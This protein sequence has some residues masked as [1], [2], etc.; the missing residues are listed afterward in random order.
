MNNEK[1]YPFTGETNHRNIPFDGG[2]LTTGEY[3]CGLTIDSKEPTEYY[4]FT[5]SFRKAFAE[6]ID[7]VAAIENEEDYDG[8]RPLATGIR[9]ILENAYNMS[10]ACLFE[11]VFDVI[12]HRPNERTN[13]SATI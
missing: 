10:N 7:H 5:E 1:K 8:V 4:K 13:T 12:K 11:Y 3:V 6:V 9:A 2:L